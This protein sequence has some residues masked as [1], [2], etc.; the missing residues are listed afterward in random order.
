VVSD[1]RYTIPTTTD[2]AILDTRSFLTFFFTN[3]NPDPKGDNTGLPDINGS[4]GISNVLLTAKKL[5]LGQEAHSQWLNLN[6][7]HW[8]KYL[9][10]RVE[11]HAISAPCLK[12]WLHYV[13]LFDRGC[14]EKTDFLNHDDDQALVDMYGADS[15]IAKSKKNILPD[16]FTTNCSF[17]GV[18][19]TEQA[20]LHGCFP[21]YTFT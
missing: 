5:E 12:T 3:V 4:G 1:W 21:T 13:N 17:D 18:T 11:C 15:S 16:K 9:L 6:V 8:G 19:T 10:M 2:T 14:Y 20:Q 7:P